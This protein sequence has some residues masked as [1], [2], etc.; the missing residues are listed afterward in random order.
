MHAIDSSQGNP[1][2]Q[3][4]A[5]VPVWAARE[6]LCLPNQMTKGPQEV[7]WLPVTEVVQKESFKESYNLMDY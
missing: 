5:N 4:A 2:H 7:T 3:Q 1:T 6:N